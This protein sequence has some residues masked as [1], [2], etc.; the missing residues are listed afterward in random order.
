[1]PEHGGRLH[2]LLLPWLPDR[3]SPVSLYIVQEYSVDSNP[4]IMLYT[5]VNVLW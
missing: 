4:G 5:V 1:M 3:Q 2:L